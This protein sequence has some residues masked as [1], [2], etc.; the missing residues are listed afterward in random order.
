MEWTHR[1]WDPE[2]TRRHAMGGA[3][4]Q[5]SPEMNKITGGFGLAP[6]QSNGETGFRLVVELEGR[7]G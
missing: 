2:R 5:G 3:W 6:H 4:G 1:W 7:D